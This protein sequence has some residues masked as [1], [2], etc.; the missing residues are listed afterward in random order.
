MVINGNVYKHVTLRY[1]Y[2]KI[3]ILERKLTYILV[4]LNNLKPVCTYI[5]CIV[6]TYIIYYRCYFIK[7]ILSIPTL[8]FGTLFSN[9]FVLLL[10]KLL[11]IYK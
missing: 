3:N 4:L 6:Y 1:I 7:F 2:I 5:L 11:N 8:V 10:F 9:K